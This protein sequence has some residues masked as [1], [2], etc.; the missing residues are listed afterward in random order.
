[1]TNVNVMNQHLNNKR[2]IEALKSHEGNAM[3]YCLRFVP[4][5]DATFQV[6]LDT[7]MA[8][9]T[10]MTRHYLREGVVFQNL[11]KRQIVAKRGL[12]DYCTV[13]VGL[14][15]ESRSDMHRKMA[16]DIVCA[17]E[18][19]VGNAK[20][21]EIAKVV[22]NVEGTYYVVSEGFDDAMMY[23]RIKKGELFDNQHNLR[24][25]WTRFKGNK[26]FSAS[27]GRKNSLS[28]FGDDKKFDAV[29][30]EAT[31]GESTKSYDG[32]FATAK[33][34]ADKTTRI[35]SK[36][37]RMGAMDTP[38]YNYLIAIEKDDSCD[39]AGLCSAHL[40]A[41]H[42]S[43]ELNV[44]HD[45]KLEE[46]CMGYILQQ[47]PATIKGASMV[48]EEQF[49]QEVAKDHKIYTVNLSNMTAEEEAMLDALLDKRFS[50][51]FSKCKKTMLNGYTAVGIV[52]SC[53][54][55]WDIYGDTNFFKDSWDYARLSG[56]NVLNVAHF[57]GNY[58][59][60]NTSGQMIK[61][62]MRAVADCPAIKAEADRV[63]KHIIDSNIKENASLNAVPQSFDGTGMLDLSYD[64]GV[65]MLLNPATYAKNPSIVLSM[66]KQK[67]N[68]FNNMFNRDRFQI[69]GHSGMISAGVD[70]W[71]KKNSVLK[72]K[73]D[74]DGRDVIEV[75][76]PVA[77]RYYDDNGIQDR[78]SIAVKYPCMGTREFVI[79]EYITEEEYISRV[80]D[81]DISAKKK[82]LIIRAVRRFK[83]GGV[84]I[85]SDLRA[86]AWFAA[87]SDEDGDKFTFL[88]I[89]I[90]GMD[91]PT[92]IL[93]SG[94]KPRAVVIGTPNNET[95]QKE[96]MTKEVFGSYAAWR[97]LGGNK[98]VG[99]VT[100][101]FKVLTEGLSQ[102]LSNP[103]VLKFYSDLLFILGDR[104]KG[105]GEYKS[106]VNRYVEANG[107][108]VCETADT[109]MEDF[110]NA[111]RGVKL[112]E[113]NVRAILEDLDVL[114]RHCQ[115]LTIDA[116]KKFYNVFCAW[117]DKMKNY[118]LVSLK[119]GIDI[120]VKYN[121]KNDKFE[122]KFLDTK[123]YILNDDST[124]IS[125]G[126]NVISI[127][128]DFGITKYFLTDMFAEYRVYAA[129]AAMAAMS[130]LVDILNQS[131]YDYRDSKAERDM[132]ASRVSYKIN[133]EAI[134][135]MER[136]LIRY[137]WTADKMFAAE[138]VAMNEALQ[139]QA[140]FMPKNTKEK[141]KREIR[142]SINAKYAELLGYI[143]NELRAWYTEYG[144][145]AIDAVT[146]V[147]SHFQNSTSV[148][149]LK[150]ERFALMAKSAD[151]ANF[152]KKL[153]KYVG[154]CLVNADGDAIVDQVTVWNGN[155]MIFPY[156]GAEPETDIMDGK[157][158]VEVRNDGV[159]LTRPYTDFVEIP[160]V[161]DTVRTLNQFVTSHDE[162][163]RLDRK[164]V[165]GE[166]YTVKVTRNHEYFL[167]NSNGENVTRLF[168]GRDE[169][170]IPGVNS[171]ERV[172]RAKRY[173]NFTGKLVAKAVNTTNSP[174]SSEYFNY[175]IVLKK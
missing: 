77:N 135:I 138:T 19:F 144:I 8:E 2:F 132:I 116:Q 95:T 147:D 79:V 91:I 13:D 9:V 88:F 170:N 86:V 114:A 97:I 130:G 121:A 133:R 122:A 63:M 20:K 96:R 141:A 27:Q 129:N 136:Q 82:S 22:I 29:L 173:L 156:Y 162:A 115:E 126:D 49:M 150:E 38:V 128:N 66:V 52:S 140:Y 59:S 90:D 87:G 81:M 15:A 51:K 74:G 72:V 58:M 31:Y 124:V 76:D 26:I 64:A 5:G 125:K 139:D 157:Y 10:P 155:L 45:E 172:V 164:L 120:D 60:A 105:N 145:S 101:S 171:S 137:I 69:P 154:E 6:L 93:K 42:V 159:Y 21:D 163:D 102:D 32:E 174:T 99:V 143:N 44:T 134:A 28:F 67:S 39:G 106:V 80:M 92:I 127:T 65:Y 18:F 111:I 50:K 165:V 55:G 108:E 71:I 148:K 53:L 151:N 109:A 142:Q 30:D 61:L 57:D 17:T 46:S 100:N 35:G 112:D 167:V 11:V 37:T 169:K 4:I 78:V 25:G 83:E 56:I 54:R 107:V 68:A 47:R 110:L 34:I 85:P 41:E 89:S 158:S 43:K 75:F 40:I 48:V 36:S 161:D 24:G 131:Y 175:I 149:V 146:Y 23:P 113:K 16:A 70:H 104:K 98:S 84:M 118:S 117:M 153:S 33:Q 119:C 166:E 123:G 152:E 7:T 168:F 103:D 1:M 73:K 14:L 62:F 3:A 12:V 160:E 94:L